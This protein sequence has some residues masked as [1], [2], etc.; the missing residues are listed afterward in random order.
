M[1]SD[2]TTG[3]SSGSDNGRIIPETSEVLEKSVVNA[4]I[5]TI[6]YSFDLL[7]RNQQILSE[8]V[9]QPK[10]VD[11][12]FGRLRSGSTEFRQLLDAVNRIRYRSDRSWI[13]GWASARLSLSAPGDPQYL[14]IVRYNDQRGTLQHSNEEVR[15]LFCDTR[16]LDYAF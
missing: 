15:L 13:F 11:S 12:F 14:H 1:S 5:E 4:L 3:G 8:A 9:N 16:M 2:A 10:P 7:S 6:A